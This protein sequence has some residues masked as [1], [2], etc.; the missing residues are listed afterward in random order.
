MV[1]VCTATKGLNEG[2]TTGTGTTEI[3]VLIATETLDTGK[4][5]ATKQENT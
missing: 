1:T 5:T 3:L 4:V 2:M